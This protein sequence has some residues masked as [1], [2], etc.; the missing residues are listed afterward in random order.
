M[1][2]LGPKGFNVIHKMPIEVEA[3]VYQDNRGIKALDRFGQILG[4][5]Q[6]EAQL[7]KLTLETGQYQGSGHQIQLNAL[8]GDWNEIRDVLWQETNVGLNAMSTYT[9]I[10]RGGYEIVWESDLPPS[11]VTGPTDSKSLG[12]GPS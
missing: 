3:T 12:A 1:D 5:D 6:Y 4:L 9:L 2:N 8:H 7:M 10:V 11:P